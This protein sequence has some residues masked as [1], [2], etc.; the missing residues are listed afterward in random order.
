MRRLLF[1]RISLLLCSFSPAVKAKKKRRETFVQRR[2]R[3]ARLSFSLLLSFCLSVFFCLSELDGPLRPLFRS[4]FGLWF[5]TIR[6]PLD[7]GPRLRCTNGQQGRRT[8]QVG[9]YAF[10][11]RNQELRPCPGVDLLLG[12]RGWGGSAARSTHGHSYEI[13][14]R[15]VSCSVLIPCC[16]KRYH[17]YLLLFNFVQSSISEHFD[18]SHRLKFLEIMYKENYASCD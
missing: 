12:E 13:V 8:A 4:S 15:F 5:V 6:L 14:C 3:K 1:Y 17:V 10:F 11:T 9:L 18:V 7:F 2:K 16:C